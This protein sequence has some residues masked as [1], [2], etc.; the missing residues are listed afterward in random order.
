MEQRCLDPLS[1]WFGGYGEPTPLAPPPPPPGLRI[2]EWAMEKEPGLWGPPCGLNCPDEIRVA[3]SGFISSGDCGPMDPIDDKL[4]S[5]VKPVTRGSPGGP[6]PRPRPQCWAWAP[7][8]IA[9]TLIIGFSFFIIFLH[10]RRSTTD[11][12]NRGT[13]KNNNKFHHPRRRASLEL[14]VGFGSAANNK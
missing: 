4:W 5:K 11:R 7:W 6:S 13:T 3:V 9:V 2:F 10:L 1:G 8:M 12:S 14:S